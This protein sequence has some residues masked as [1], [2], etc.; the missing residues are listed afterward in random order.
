VL[1]A[2]LLRPFRRVRCARAGCRS[3]AM[4]GRNRLRDPK[5]SDGCS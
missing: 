4:G 1:P 5:N 3:A 2:G